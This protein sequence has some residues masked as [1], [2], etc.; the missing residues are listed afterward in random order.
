[1]LRC[2]SGPGGSVQRPE[3]AGEDAGGPPLPA[4]REA[5][6][7]GG[8]RP[9]HDHPGPEQEEESGGTLKGTGPSPS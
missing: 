4:D 9:R 5:Q 7:G 1:M 3:G 8:S 6:P 2:S